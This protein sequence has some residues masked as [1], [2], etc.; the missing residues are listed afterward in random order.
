MN[1][2]SAYFSL[3]LIVGCAQQKAP[4]IEPESTAKPEVRVVE[5]E[6]TVLP[7]AIEPVVLPQ[8][9]PISVEPTPE[10]KAKPK[11]KQKAMSV[12]TV[13]KTHDGKLILGSEEW[14]W[15]PQSKQYIKAKIESDQKVSM[16]GVSDLQDF[17][18]DGVDWVSFSTGDEKLELPVERW[19]GQKDS[20]SRQAV[21]KLRVKLGELDE[22]AEV[23]LTDGKQ[24]VLG[25]NFIRDVAVVDGKR[26]FVQP[27][28]K[29]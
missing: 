27:K 22:L 17:E 4:I 9:R 21:V 8:P 26:K 3:T 6:P 10:V 5:P 12:R 19:W 24:M 13:T 11:Q 29:K 14:V 2:A 20:D 7:V 23:A 1:K 25:D 16:M 15:L 18:R 28:A